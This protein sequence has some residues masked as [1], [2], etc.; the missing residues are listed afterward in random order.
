M[1][2]ITNDMSTTLQYLPED[3]VSC[4]LEGSDE[5]KLTRDQIADVYLGKKVFMLNPENN[6]LGLT[7]EFNEDEYKK[8]SIYFLD[9]L[10][11][12]HWKN[13]MSL[14]VKHQRIEIAS[15]HLKDMAVR[16]ADKI[17]LGYKACKNDGMPMIASELD[18]YL[19]AIKFASLR[20][21]QREDSE[22]PSEKSDLLSVEK[23]QLLF[24]TKIAKDM[25]AQWADYKIHRAFTSNKSEDPSD[26]KL[27]DSNYACQAFLHHPEEVD[28]LRWEYNYKKM[29][30][31]NMKITIAPKEGGFHHM[32]SFEGSK[33]QMISEIMRK[34]GELPLTVDPQKGFV[35]YNPQETI[36]ALPI[37]KVRKTGKPADDY[38]VV[39]KS[40]VHEGHTH[41]WLELKDPMYRYSAG[42]SFKIGQKI[43]PYSPLSAVQGSVNSPDGCEFL[44]YD[45]KI[46]KTSIAISSEQFLKLKNHIESMRE[47]AENAPYNIV[48]KNCTSF[49]RE[50]LSQI[51]I[52]LPSKDG[53]VSN[54]LG[55]RNATFTR[56]TPTGNHLTNLAYR[57][58]AP[59]RNA[60]MYFFGGCYAPQS[61]ST[62]E[63][64]GAVFTSAW[65]IFNPEAGEVDSPR[66]VRQWQQFVQQQREKQLERLTASRAFDY[67]NKDEQKKELDKIR[68]G[69]PNIFLEA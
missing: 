25:V 41:C 56:S 65:D 32:F 40:L 23:A 36:A 57:A 53:D 33:P 16:Y 7:A 6:T 59:I 43:S 18:R 39:I 63:N 69:N 46:V 61:D 17:N 48:S 35:R 9:K 14:E 64:T 3:F 62:N 42:Y 58:L 8:V 34:K 37:F 15:L 30:R 29:A 44:G 22:S 21:V 60:I 52:K 5:P 10:K 27:M 1:G 31:L 47:N 55:Y 13:P 67:L 68:Y 12:I 45:D 54:I 2:S 26:D 19:A 28:C 49:V 66:R 38:R 11:G 24:S 20:D 4:Q 51:D 50:V